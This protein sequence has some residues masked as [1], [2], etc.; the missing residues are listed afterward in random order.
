MRWS[1][2]VRPITSDSQLE[3]VL[4]GDAAGE[5]DQLLQGLGHLVMKI[6]YIVRFRFRE[7]KARAI[8][9]QRCVDMVEL[10]VTGASRLAGYRH[11]GEAYEFFALPIA[12]ARIED[13]PHSVV[14]IEGADKEIAVARRRGD[15]EDLIGLVVAHVKVVIDAVAGA[16]R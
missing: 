16:E 14:G 12:V 1:Q 5:H 15:R 6:R 9:N 2:T 10:V 8:A 7:E 3:D 11:H 4:L 13:V